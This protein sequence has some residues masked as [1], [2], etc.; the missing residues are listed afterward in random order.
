LVVLIKSS[1]SRATTRLE[2]SHQISLVLR[3]NYFM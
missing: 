3:K 2:W 1:A